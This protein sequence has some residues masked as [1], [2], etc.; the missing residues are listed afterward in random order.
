MHKGKSANP[1]KDSPQKVFDVSRPGKTSPGSTS[2]P[3]IVGHKPQVKDPMMSERTDTRPLLDA[4]KKVTLAVPSDNVVASTVTEATPAP[5][6]L[7]ALVTSSNVEMAAP[8]APET[9]NAPNNVPIE[10]PDK[11]ADPAPSRAP[12][13]PI[14]PMQS[15]LPTNQPAQPITGG[16]TGVVFDDAPVQTDPMPQ[17]PTNTNTEPLPVLSGEPTDMTTQA[18]VVVS[19]HNH[20]NGWARFIVTFIVLAVIAV[21]IVDILLDSGLIIKNG[22]PHTHFF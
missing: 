2:R 4:T 3:V 19:H 15:P 14:Q 5:A 21:L 1:K 7:A 20:S 9:P 11:F 8:L 12:E 13:E 22:I 16:T 6:D 17:T 18:K 10:T